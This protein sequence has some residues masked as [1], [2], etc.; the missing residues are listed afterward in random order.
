VLN[1]PGRT[2][3]IT[4]IIDFVLALWGAYALLMI[5]SFST[6]LLPERL[7]DFSYKLGLA[8]MLSSFALFYVVA[9]AL[10]SSLPQYWNLAASLILWS[11]LCYVIGLVIF[12]AY[13]MIKSRLARV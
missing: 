10:G 8:F 13:K 4:G 11:P 12:N 5:V 6:D 7:C 1:L 3:I 9:L 2:I